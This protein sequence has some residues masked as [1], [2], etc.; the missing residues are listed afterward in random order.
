MK[1]KEFKKKAAKLFPVLVALALA[2]GCNNNYVPDPADASPGIS[3]EALTYKS[4]ARAAATTGATIEDFSVF[5]TLDG[6]AS[7][8]NL[9][10]AQV[11]RSDGQW[12]YTPSQYWPFA[13]TIDFYAYSPYGSTGVNANYSASDVSDLSLTYAVAADPAQQEDF[14]VAVK[15]GIS[16]TQPAVVHLHFQHVLSRVALKAKSRFAGLSYKI[17]SVSFLN[18]KNEG[19][20]ALTPE[21]IPASGGFTY[22][23]DI[24]KP[25][26][27]LWTSTDAADTRYAF[28]FSASP[29]EVNSSTAYTDVLTGADALMLLPQQTVLGDEASTVAYADATHPADPDDGKLY[30]KLVYGNATTSNKVAAYFP[31]KEPLNP[32]AH[33]PITFEAGRQYTFTVELTT[34]EIIAF[35]VAVSDFDETFPP[36]GLTPDPDPATAKTYRPKAHVGWAGSNIYWRE[37]PTAPDGGY[38]TFDDIG[39]TSQYGGLFF[40]W[41]SLVGLSAEGM[42]SEPWRTGMIL[43]IPAGV[44]GNYRPQTGASIPLPTWGDIPF[45]TSDHLSAITNDEPTF[46]Y[47]TYLNSDPENVSGFKGDICAYLSGRAGVPEGYWRMPTSEEFGTVAQYTLTGSFANRSDV[48]PDGTSL[49]TAGYYY[50]YDGKHSGASGVFFPASGGRFL[51]TGML[52][53]VGKEAHAWSSSPYGENGAYMGGGATPVKLYTGVLRSNGVP[54]RCVKK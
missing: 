28:D 12:T 43:Y 5:A 32:S 34:S 4:M 24:T 16:A 51:P 8:T 22:E 26:T 17:Y 14:L 1:R 44:N 15:T 18:L 39:A 9:Q 42:M 35:E 31:V 47:T 23:D 41:G 7:L 53:E 3:F 54:V 25:Y 40:K 48:E 10:G 33:R 37:D 30:I 50:D 49:F 13:G 52:N 46:G 29:I 11:S 21:N 20:L 45:G 19:K 38:L 36:A 6:A 2:Q 27:V